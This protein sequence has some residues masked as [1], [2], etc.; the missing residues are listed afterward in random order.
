VPHRRRP[1]VRADRPQHVTLRLREGVPTLRRA[2]AFRVVRSAIRDAHKS[3]FVVV[4]FAALRNHVHLV[5]EARDGDCLSR[6]VQGLKVRLTLR[7]NALSGGRG[8]IFD[9]RFHAREI[10]TP[11]QA[12]AVLGYVLGA[13]AVPA[14]RPP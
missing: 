2:R 13:H 12:R 14:S 8:T 6:G 1:K 4:H 5:V 10:A 9:D 3:G 11:R 7:L